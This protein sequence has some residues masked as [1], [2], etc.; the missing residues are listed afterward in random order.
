MDMDSLELDKYGFDVSATIQ[1]DNV[2]VESMQSDLRH[3]KLEIESWE[4]C[5]QRM[6]L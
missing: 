3:V 1:R 5:S 6:T 2:F 4:N